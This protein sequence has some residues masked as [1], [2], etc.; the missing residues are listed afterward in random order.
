MNAKYLPIINRVCKERE[1]NLKLSDI[2]SV[3]ELKEDEYRYESLLLHCRND[4]EMFEFI[5]VVIDT[6]T[7]YVVYVTEVEGSPYSCDNLHLVYNK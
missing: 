3:K 5:M 2:K 4:E 7:R 6:I 1:I